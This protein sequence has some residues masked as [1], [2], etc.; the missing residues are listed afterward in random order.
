[1]ATTRIAVVTTDQNGFDVA[2]FRDEA[3]A[4][5]H[6]H[7]TI[8]AL[9][10]DVGNIRDEATIDG[11]LDT[12]TRADVLDGTGVKIDVCNATRT[13]TGWRVD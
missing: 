7:R 9:G 12:D 11:L 5:R 8:T 6:I 1:M 2:F 3:A 13:R 4:G 10:V